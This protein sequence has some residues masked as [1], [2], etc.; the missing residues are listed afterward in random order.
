[1][2]IRIASFA[3]VALLSL[4]ACTRQEPPSALE[5]SEKRDT[6][7]RTAGRAAYKI[8][9]ETKAAAKKAGRELSKATKEAREGWKEASGEART[10]SSK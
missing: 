5:N 10:G 2:K 8:A 4:S 9:E 6:P 7:A 1:V 3:G